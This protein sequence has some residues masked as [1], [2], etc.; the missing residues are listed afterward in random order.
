MY[1]YLKLTGTKK[2]FMNTFLILIVAHMEMCETSKLQPISAAFLS[3][4]NLIPFDKLYFK[5]I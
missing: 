5:F 1:W 3:Y 2:I 4:V